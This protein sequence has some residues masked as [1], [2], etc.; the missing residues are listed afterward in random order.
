MLLNDIKQSRHNTH[1]SGSMNI[2]RSP[3]KTLP[4]CGFFNIRFLCRNKI[5]HRK[6]NGGNKG[7]VNRYFSENAGQ[8]MLPDVLYFH[9][10]SFAVNSCTSNSSSIYF[11]GH[12]IKIFPAIK[13]SPSILPVSTICSERSKSCGLAPL[14]T[15]WRSSPDLSFM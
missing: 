11:D 12:F 4:R 3:G 9:Q 5:C 13:V 8:Q 6:R 14:K 1:H 15:T 7:S 10:L 2:K